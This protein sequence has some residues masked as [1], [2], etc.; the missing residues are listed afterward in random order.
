MWAGKKVKCPACGQ[1]IVAKAS[2]SV[3]ADDRTLPPLEAPSSVSA[4][5]EAKN[6]ATNLQEE[7][8]T[9]KKSSEAAAFAFKQIEDESTGD[10]DQLWDFPAPPQASDEIGRLGRIA[11]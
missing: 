9:P 5:E 6:L 4:V 10:A 11:S 1:V 2:A 3:V 8:Q 7:S